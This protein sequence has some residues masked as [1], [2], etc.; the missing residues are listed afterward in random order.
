VSSEALAKE[1]GASAGYAVPHRCHG[2]LP[3]G[4]HSSVEKKFLKILL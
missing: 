2:F 4:L 1:I 3:V